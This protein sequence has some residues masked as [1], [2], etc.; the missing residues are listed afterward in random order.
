MIVFLALAALFTPSTCS[1]L[2]CLQQMSQDV[3]EPDEANL[4]TS[5]IAQGQQMIY[6]SMYPSLYYEMNLP[7]VNC[8]SR[9]SLKLMG[10]DVIPALGPEFFSG[11]DGI[12][13]D[14][15]VLHLDGSTTY[16]S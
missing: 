10:A 15:S 11:E 7:V 8:S 12:G 13:I 5:Q 16:G 3:I 4:A 1:A 2:I 14:D 9:E 6:S